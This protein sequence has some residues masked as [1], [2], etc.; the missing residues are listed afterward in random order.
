MNHLMRPKNLF[1]IGM[2]GSGKTTIGQALARRLKRPF[3]DSDQEIEKHTGVQIAL[4]FELEQEAGFRRREAKMLDSL[5]QRSGIVLA[6]GGGAVLRAE[7]RAWLTNRGTVIYLHAC[8][9]N[10]WSRLRHDKNR[11]LLRN[12]DPL[13]TLEALYVQ[14]DPL[15]R[16]CAD[17]VV[18]ILTADRPSIDTAVNRVLQATLP[19]YSKA[20]F[21]R[22]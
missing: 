10:L 9:Q 3:F 17:H 5:T 15:Y 2:M 16:A 8:A 11:P 14:R 12:P 18:D 13:A 6:T 19:S 20:N 21:K 1:L 4:I 7:N 22:W